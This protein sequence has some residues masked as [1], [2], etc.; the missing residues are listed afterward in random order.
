M[1]VDQDR[2]RGKRHGRHEHA[3][4][5]AQPKRLDGQ[6]QRRRPRTQRHR[7][8]SPDRRRECVFKAADPGTGGEPSGSKGLDDF[9]DLVVA[10]T[11]LE[12]GDRA[13]RGLVT[14]EALV[15]PFRVVWPPTA[16]RPH[17]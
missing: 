2:G 5:G 9:V 7:V 4:T 17:E 1:A 12:E 16:Q 10:E 13:R 14:H 15:D 6:M 11:G 8:S 3:G